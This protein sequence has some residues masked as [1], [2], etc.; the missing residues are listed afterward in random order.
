M[1]S[2]LEILRVTF[3]SWKSVFGKLLSKH[4][5]RGFALDF[6]DILSPQLFIFYAEAQ[7]PEEVKLSREKF[8]QSMLLLTF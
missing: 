8:L 3:K 6:S 4:F 1:V 7:E 2:V 5:S